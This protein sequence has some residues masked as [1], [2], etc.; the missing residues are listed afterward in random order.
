MP[1]SDTGCCYACSGRVAGS[2]TGV[3]LCMAGPGVEGG[4]EGIVVDVCVCV[5]W[6][7]GDGVA[8]DLCGIVDVC[9]YVCVCGGGG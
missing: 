5:G 2:D 6:G 9:Q 3:L 1:E 7:G 8:V 4:G